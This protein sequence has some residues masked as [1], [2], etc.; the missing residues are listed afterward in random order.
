ML[1][2]TSGVYSQSP[3]EPAVFRRFEEPQYTEDPSFR[4][5]SPTSFSKA[6]EF[7]AFPHKTTGE[8][9]TTASKEIMCFSLT[10]GL[11]MISLLILPPLM[12][13][14][15]MLT[16]LTYK[17]FLPIYIP[18][19]IIAASASFLVAYALVVTCFFWCC[20]REGRT[21]HTLVLSL[22]SVLTLLAIVMLL[23][24]GVIDSEVNT[25]VYDLVEECGSST[26]SS[27][28]YEYWS[29]MNVVRQSED[30]ANLVSVTECDG[31]YEEEPYTA[32]LKNIE[33]NLMCSGVCVPIPSS[34]VGLLQSGGGRVRKRTRKS[35]QALKGT[36]LIPGGPADGPNQV[37]PS[38]MAKRYVPVHGS[39]GNLSLVQVGNNRV[40]ATYPPTLFS[41]NNYQSSCSAMAGYELKY[42]VLGTV[43]LMYFEGICILIA[44]IVF[45]FAMFAIMSNCE[46]SI[47][48]RLRWGDR[49]FLKDMNMNLARAKEALRRS[50]EQRRKA[51]KHVGAVL[52]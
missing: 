29:S 25:V 2:P 48:H 20:R 23:M 43:S 30:C 17:L 10:Y 38:L 7:S 14:V 12:Q 31:F 40:N 46:P 19:L 4:V 47:V 1:P 27:G 15:S 6:T 13:A 39:R 21:Q 42:K 16:N 35:L 8:E 34:P 11:G 22:G 49:P 41:H 32:Y 44:V 3:G 36:M 37:K 52:I 28:L 9:P 26:V 5:H 50:D 18:Y 45:G 51:Q 33:V 24:A